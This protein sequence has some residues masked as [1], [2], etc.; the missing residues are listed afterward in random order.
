MIS[1]IDQIN[2]LYRVA[3]THMIRHSYVHPCT[4]ERMHVSTHTYTSLSSVDPLWGQKHQCP[5]GF[6]PYGIML[7]RYFCLLGWLLDMVFIWI[8]NLFSFE[9]ICS[10]EERGGW[11]WMGVAIRSERR[12]ALTWRTRADDAHLKE[13][14]RG[15]VYLL[16]LRMLS[17]NGFK[18]IK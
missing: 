16:K 5:C 13:A 9:S 17:N 7:G 18:T 6:L 8:G 10:A 12:S 11:L 2:V 14:E 3:T 1:L 15:E 4:Y